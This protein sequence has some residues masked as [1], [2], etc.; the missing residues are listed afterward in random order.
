V[1]ANKNVIVCVAISPRL[2]V[3]VDAN[4]TGRKA[5]GLLKPSG[6]NIIRLPLL[7]P[8]GTRSQQSTR[9]SGYT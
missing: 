4:R 8:T 3:E 5:T 7:R 1:S 2:L 9:L 6:Q